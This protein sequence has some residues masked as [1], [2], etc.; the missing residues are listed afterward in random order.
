[1][2]DLRLGDHCALISRSMLTS[3]QRIDAQ[4][5]LLESARGEGSCCL[6]F[7]APAI[8][9]KVSAVNFKKAPRFYLLRRCYTFRISH[10]GCFLWPLNRKFSR[11]DLTHFLPRFVSPSVTK[12][13]SS[14]L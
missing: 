6:S 13:R 11:M 8:S 2:N 4:M 1:M 12:S 10:C 3:T 7:G 5:P 9:L 14:Q